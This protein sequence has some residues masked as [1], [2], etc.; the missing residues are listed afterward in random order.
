MNKIFL[1]VLC[2][3]FLSGC[4]AKY[5][6]W[7]RVEL[8]REHTLQV[9]SYNESARA[10]PVDFTVMTSEQIAVYQLGEVNKRLANII[11]GKRTKRKSEVPKGEFTEGVTAFF[12]G[13]KDI[14]STPAG[15]AL[16]TLYGS[17]L[18]LGAGTGDTTS[19]KTTGDKSGGISE[20]NEIDNVT[21]TTTT[22]TGL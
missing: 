13:V 9:E 6:A 16:S 17:S 11:D 14:V 5:E 4:A 3:C 7:E 8:E 15:A 19:V 21:T 12:G 10:L 1:T 2:I 20:V 22:G 18:V